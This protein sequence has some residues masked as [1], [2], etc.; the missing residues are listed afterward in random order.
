M[1]ENDNSQRFTEREGENGTI[2]LIDGADV[3]KTGISLF[4]T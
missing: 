3:V 1:I 2:G 4:K